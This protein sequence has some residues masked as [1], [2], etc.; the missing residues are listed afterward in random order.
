[1][2]VLGYPTGLEAILAKAETAAVNDILEASGMNPLRIADGLAAQRLIRPSATQGHIGDV[3]KTDIVFDAPTTHGG[4]GGPVF[5]KSG[6]VIAVEYAVLT[7]FGGKLLRG[8]HALR[9]GAPAPK[10]KSG[11]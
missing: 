1:M 10:G 4:S 3:T 8:A 2:V 9:A 11:G 7:S 5:N 6:Q